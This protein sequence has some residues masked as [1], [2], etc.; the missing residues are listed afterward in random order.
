MGGLT[1]PA[2]SPLPVAIRS[3]PVGSI[4]GR[5]PSVGSSTPSMMIKEL[6][7]RE[8]RL[9]LLRADYHTPQKFT[10]TEWQDPRQPPA[11]WYVVYR[12][13]SAGLFVAVAVCSVL[14][15]GREGQDLGVRYVKWPI[16]LTNWGLACC[17]LQAALGAGLATAN[18]VQER[19]Q[20]RA[21]RDAAPSGQ[22]GLG[23]PGAVLQA[24]SLPLLHRL[25]WVLN[26]ISITVAIGITCTYWV[27][28]YDPSEH[29]LDALNIL[30]HAANSALMLVDVL[31]SAHPLRLLHAF[32][33]LL[34][35]FVYLS[36]SLV[37]FLAGGT[38]RMD[39]TCVYPVLDWERP[40][41]TTVVCVL[42]L[43]FVVAVHTAVWAL[44]LARRRVARSLREA[45]AA[46]NK[47]EKKDPGVQLDAMA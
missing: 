36:F 30:V 28:V 41:R 4:S 39:R 3:G 12:W 32:W 1:T 25:Y 27:A 7:R 26:T 14:D 35:V 22:G 9:D 11:L 34:F 29:V 42:G 24:P 5:R 46:A 47:G 33:P 21:E 2:Y 8:L 17:C 40:T 13:L 38:D 23:S 43:S 16:Y 19:R 10:Q 37:Y 31:M 45:K 18:F 20:R 15:A 6:W 44:Q